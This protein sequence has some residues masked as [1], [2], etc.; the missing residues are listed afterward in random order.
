MMKLRIPKTKSWWTGLLLMTACAFSSHAHA[1][2]A[3]ESPAETPSEKPSETPNEKPSETPSGEPSETPD[4][5][6]DA[7]PDGPEG[8]SASDDRG[9]LGQSDRAAAESL[10]RVGRGLMGLGQYD[11]A[12][13]KL[14]QSI[15][16]FPS[17]GTAMS[18]GE[19]REKQGKVASAW[20][21]YRHAMTH[22]RVADDPEL[23]KAQNRAQ[24]IEALV[25][26]LTMVAAQR[27]MTM[28][29]YRDDTKFGVGVFGVPLA[30]DPGVHEIR[31]EAD[32]FE[33]WTTT[34]QLKASE[35]LTVTVPALKPQVKKKKQVVVRRRQQGPLFLAGVIT[36]AAGVATIGIGAILGIAAARDITTVESDDSLCG[37]DHQCTPAGRDLVDAA[38]SKAVASTIAFAVGGI[39]V[40]AGFTLVVIESSTRTDGGDAVAIVPLVVPRGGGLSVHASF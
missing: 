3:E 10:A 22:Y 8:G 24:R 4:E 7:A 25:P 9:V 17:G 23:H 27:L 18:L 20:A 39:A 30:V 26:K 21:A 5:T 16:A 40:A 13:P 37:D 31:V 12:C 29:V 33:S 6:P 35:R 36:G 34:V 38:E 32:G 11:E 28:S 2:G 1:Q 15:E 19:C 14:E